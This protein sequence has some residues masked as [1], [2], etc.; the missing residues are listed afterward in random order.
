V[1]FGYGPSQAIS[2]TI[3][4]PTGVDQLRSVSLDQ[5]EMQTLFG[6]KVRLRVSG[7]VSSAAP[8]DVTPRQVVS[9]AN[10]LRLTIL[11]GGGN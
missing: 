9:I 3:A 5:T 1:Q 7:L 2:K 8:I 10:R 11:I 6:Q 4:M